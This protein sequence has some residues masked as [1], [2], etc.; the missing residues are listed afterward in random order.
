M[1]WCFCHMT[2]WDTQWPML[3]DIDPSRLAIDNIRRPFLLRHFPHKWPLLWIKRLLPARKA[4]TRPENPEEELIPKWNGHLTSFRVVS[5]A[6]CSRISCLETLGRSKSNK[7]Y[8]KSGKD[9]RLPVSFCIECC[10]L[11]RVCFFANFQSSY[12]LKKL[13]CNHIYKKIFVTEFWMN[14]SEFKM[15]LRSF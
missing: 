2:R 12:L 4:G 11:C 3:R 1:F 10:S 7:C 9:F 14:L 8:R 6:L 15:N 13:I 5:W